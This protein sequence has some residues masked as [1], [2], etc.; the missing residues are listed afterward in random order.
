VAL[1]LGLALVIGH[2]QLVIPVILRICVED[3]QGDKTEFE[4]LS[5][6]G[7]SALLSFKVKIMN[8][9]PSKKRNS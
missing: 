5:V 9:Y 6:R 8:K 2:N 3:V 1:G 7:D 4:D